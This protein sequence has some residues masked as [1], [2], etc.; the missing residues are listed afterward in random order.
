MK[1]KPK[2]L[3]VTSLSLIVL[4]TL[5]IYVSLN[6]KKTSAFSEAIN[7]LNEPDKKEDDELKGKF[8]EVLQDLFKNR[9]IAILN[10]DLEELKKFYDLEK[11]PS[12]WAYESESKKVKYL[13][14]WSQKQGVVF[15]EI[16]SKTEIRKAREREKDLYGI[17][18]VVSSEF[19][20]YYLNDP[21]KTNTF[22]LGTYH[23]LNLKDEGDRYIITKE[24]YTDP[25]ADSLDLNNIKSDEIKSYILNSSS[26]SYSPD[27]RTQ[28]AIDYAHTY[29]GAAADDELG[30]NYNKKYTDFNPQ[31]G[32]C[33]NFAS[34]ILFE[35]GGFKKNSAWNYSDGEGS[36][37]WV[38]AQAF[39]N[40]MVN[41]GRASYIAKGKYSEIYKAAYN[42]RPGDF[43]AYEKNGRITHISTVTGLDSKGYP[44]VTCHNTDRLLVPF[45]LGWSNDNIRFHLV[46]V[47]Y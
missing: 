4:L 13:N 18:C 40:Y 9:N 3:L 29:C 35:G 1:R 46:D 33:A 27:E 2:I 23:Y 32:D 14:N 44:L 25:F 38:N 21:L 17:I 12:L 26:P 36:K 30:F 8:E 42:L 45:D 34:Q 19:T 43:V 37:A 5:S 39:K 10:N 6:K 31:G 22:R 16:K 28:K 20:Y 41:S 47:Y 7:L 24:W 15:N 11:K